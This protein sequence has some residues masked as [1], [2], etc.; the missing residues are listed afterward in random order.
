L[1]VAGRTS[2]ETQEAIREL[3]EEVLPSLA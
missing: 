3:V 1:V 2:K